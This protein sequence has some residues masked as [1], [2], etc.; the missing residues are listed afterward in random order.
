MQISQTLTGLPGVRSCLVAMATG[1]NLE[2]LT[3]MGFDEPA[4]AGPND[5][6]VA[7][8]ADDEPALAAALERL[9]VELVDAGGS[10]PTAGADGGAGRAPRTVGSAVRSFGASLALVSTPGRVAFA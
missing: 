9:E 10:G 6:L 5:M 7:L 3:G 8:A 1:L 4:G 2:L